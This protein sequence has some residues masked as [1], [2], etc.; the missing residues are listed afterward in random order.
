MAMAVSITINNLS[1]LI[2]FYSKVVRLSVL[3]LNPRYLKVRYSVLSV[4]LGMV[5][6]CY[7]Y[8]WSSLGMI[9]N[10]WVTE[11]K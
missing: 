11:V 5:V 8:Y 7:P 4:F 6:P 3:L 9:F 1:F 2:C 10:I